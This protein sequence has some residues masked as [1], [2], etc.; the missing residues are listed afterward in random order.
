[1][2]RK[3]IIWHHFQS[4]GLEPAGSIDREETTFSDSERLSVCDLEVS[5]ESKDCF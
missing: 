5:R 2:R 4:P 1:M 3:E